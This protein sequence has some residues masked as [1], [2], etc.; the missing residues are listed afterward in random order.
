MNL[1]FES[2]YKNVY[3]IGI[4]GISM[5]GLA[6]ILNKR[7]VNIS[8]SDI[9]TSDTTNRLESLGIHINYGHKKENIKKDIDLVVFTAAVKEDNPEIIG[10]KELGIK[11]IERSDLLGD[12]MADYA[13]SVAISG[14]HGKTTTT[15]MLSEILIASKADPT[16]SL[17]GILSTIGGNIKVGSSDIF[18]A[19]AC[20]YHNSFLKFKPFIA[21]VLNVEE[22]HLDFFGSLREIQT[23]FKNFAANVCE[24]GFII[25]NSQTK[26]LDYIISEAKG[27]VITYGIDTDSNWCAKNIIHNPDGTNSFDAVFQ[28]KNMGRISLKIPGEHNILNALAACAAAVAL[29]QKMRDIIQGLDNYTGVNRRFQTKGTYK[30][31]TIVDDYAHHPTE[32]KATLAAAQNI[33]HKKLWCIFQ[34]HT[35]T[36]LNALFDEFGNSF[37]DADEIIVTDIYSAREKDT[38][39]VHSRDLVK[40]LNE[41]G[42]KAQYISSFEDIV[43]HIKSTAKEGDLLITMGAGDIYIVGETLIKQ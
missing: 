32:I 43:T 17:G 16:I 21:I 42:N 13:Q 33:R 23:S 14:T 10:A 6:E 1:N 15:S 9:K 2:T 41:K 7:G 12:I 35:Y 5:S 3:F 36:R 30:G 18:V 11:I 28:N 40:R 39:L 8:G 27:S 24:G 4:G 29:G 38:G 25:I 37:F 34:P 20:E 31:I 19:E 26:G 22:E